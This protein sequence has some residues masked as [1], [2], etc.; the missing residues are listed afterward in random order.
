MR[1]RKRCLLTAVP[2]HLHFYTA[3][4]VGL[5]TDRSVGSLFVDFFFFLVFKYLFMYVIYMLYAYTL[6]IRKL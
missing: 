1:T 6:H 3:T 2:S 4:T 5:D